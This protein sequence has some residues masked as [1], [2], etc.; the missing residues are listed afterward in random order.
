M[1]VA[2]NSGFPVD[3]NQV[4]N[5][6]IRQSVLCD[7]IFDTCTNWPRI[8][9]LLADASDA[10]WS[11]PGAGLRATAMPRHEDVLPPLRAGR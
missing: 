4:G 5:Q 1:V 11:M 3:Q 8:Q 2:C 9:A 7:F 10:V 6:A